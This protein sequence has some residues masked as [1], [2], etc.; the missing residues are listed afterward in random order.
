VYKPLVHDFYVK[1]EENEQKL[2][3]AART[4]TYPQE[5]SGIIS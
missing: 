3:N 1:N 5:T 4:L 2:R